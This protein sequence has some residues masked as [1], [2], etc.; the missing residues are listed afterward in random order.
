MKR[1]LIFLAVTSNPYLVQC[2]IVNFTSNAERLRRN[3]DNMEKIIFNNYN[4]YIESKSSGK[5]FCFSE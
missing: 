5:A 1:L 4:E 3:A 2:L